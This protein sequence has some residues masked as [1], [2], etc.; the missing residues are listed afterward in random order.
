MN[1]E[2]VT[3]GTNHISAANKYVHDNEFA[4]EFYKK[5][6]NL[7]NTSNNSK[8]SL[9]F[10]AFQE[11]RYAVPLQNYKGSIHR[12]HSDSGG[13]QIVTVGKKMTPELYKEIY[14]LQARYS[15]IA[16]SFDEIP[17]AKISEK[18][19]INDFT[20]RKFDVD[21]YKEFAKLSGKNLRE[22][23]ETFKDEKVSCKP[24]LIAH[25]NCL[26]TYKDWIDIILKEVPSSDHHLIGGIS[27]SGAALGRGF[28]EDMQKAAYIS[29]FPMN[30]YV[31][32]LGVGSIKRL[33]PYLLFAQNGYYKKDFHLSYDSSSHSQGV[34]TGSFFQNGGDSGLGR[35]MNRNY[36]VIYG[37]MDEL[38][39]LRERGYT[40]SD[41]FKCFSKR[42]WGDFTDDRGNYILE[43]IRRNT[44]L[45]L[46]FFG[47]S[48]YN[49]TKMVDDCRQS[50]DYLLE[51][52]KK[53]K[54]G[55]DISVL[56]NI[57]NINDFEYWNKH[58]GH[59][60]KSKKIQRTASE[61]LRGLF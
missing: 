42:T 57:N 21:N 44:T 2:Y 39:H 8:F 56:Y 26:E 25:G 45:T 48:V 40:N 49:F 52:S 20:S 46:S 60:I 10:N 58:Y 59:Y 37:Q 27:V 15:D 1:L 38:F 32:L 5:V 47:R 50:K 33:L 43:D 19:A 3:S 31:H 16:M 18:S 22:Q 13:L 29:E 23:I 14:I 12:I 35:V 41:F 17:V 51:T 34:T 55:R 30:H 7:L 61:S 6:F 24:L 53:M 9:L 28:L 4:F 11:Q 54:L 36:E